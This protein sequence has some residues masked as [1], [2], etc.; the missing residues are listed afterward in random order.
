MAKIID[1]RVAEFLDSRGNPKTVEADVILHRRAAG[2]CLRHFRCF[3]RFPRR[4]WN[5]V[6]RQE[7]LSGQRCTRQSPYQMVPIRELLGR[8]ADR[9][10]WPGPPR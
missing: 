7:P 1:I 2:S 10:G 3:Y 8:D 5:C 6:R 4:R 9:S